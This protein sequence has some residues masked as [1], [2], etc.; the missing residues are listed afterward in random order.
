M[1]RIGRTA[2]VGKPGKAISLA[3]ENCVLNLE[4]IE[5]LIGQKIPVQY[6]ADELFIKDKSFSGRSGRPFRQGQKGHDRARASGRPRHLRPG[7]SRT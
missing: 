6:A 7:F 1:H 5:S 4:A 3:C 2:R